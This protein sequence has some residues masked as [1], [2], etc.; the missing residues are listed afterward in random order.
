MSHYIE[1]FCGKH[2]HWDD[3]VD[4]LA[5]GCPACIADGSFKTRQQLEARIKELEA[6]RPEA[7]IPEPTQ[8]MWD[9]G[10]LAI[11]ELYRGEGGWCGVKAAEEQAR[12]TWF[13]MVK[14]WR[15]PLRLKEGE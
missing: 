6:T 14:A 8:A 2:G 1:R 15:S 3:D 4:N 7:L 5:E 13:V 12:I 10:A 11:T 9:A